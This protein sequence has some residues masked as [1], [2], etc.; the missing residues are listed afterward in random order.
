VLG[1]T[2]GIIGTMQ[3][4][5]AVKVLA[6]LGSPLK[7]KLLI[8]DFSDM[9]FA[10]LDV[11][12]RDDCTACQS[13]IAVPKSTEKLVWL[14]GRDT[15]NIN[16]EKPA[17]LRFSEVYESVKRHFG[18]RMKSRLAIIFEYKTFEITL[19]N[20]GR[21]LIKNVRSESKALAV[22]REIMARLAK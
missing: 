4:M 15:A 5:E 16:P 1:V 17:K 11:F 21:M 8:C 20:S 10:T 2:A 18:I 19:F 14:C 9:Y 13:D 22:Y 3:A 7:G 12:K 6:G